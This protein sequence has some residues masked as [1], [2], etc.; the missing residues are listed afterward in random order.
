MLELKVF[1]A[2][3]LPSPILTMPPSR[4]KKALLDIH[5]LTLCLSKTSNYLS[6]WELYFLS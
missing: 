1:S 2:G 4:L 5:P 6:G 3:P